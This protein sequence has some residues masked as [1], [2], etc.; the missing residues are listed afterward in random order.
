MKKTLWVLLAATVLPVAWAKKPFFNELTREL[1]FSSPSQNILC[2]GDKVP[3]EGD[4]EGYKKG[5]EC[6]VF[7]GEGRMPTLPE[8][9]TPKDCD[10]SPGI[11]VFSVEA[12]G[13][14]KREAICQ[15]ASYYQGLEDSIAVLPYGETLRGQGWQCTSSERGM[16]CEN[17]EKNGFSLS[18]ARQETFSAGASDDSDSA[19]KG[20]S[21]SEDSGTASR[22]SDGSSA[23]FDVSGLKKGNI[24]RNCYKSPC[25]VSK[26][27]SFKN[28][29][30][31]GD[32]ITVD[33]ELLGGES[34]DEN[35][36]VTWND[37]THTVSIHCSK[38]K[39][40]T[41]LDGKV[42]YLPIGPNYPAVLYSAGQLYMETC[43]NFK[44]YT[45]EDGAEKFGYHLENLDGETGEMRPAGS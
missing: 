32:G 10:V 27:V 19:G 25:A 18:R 28:R 17:G 11:T 34:D 15:Q 43:H 42:E 45:V 41:T 7:S 20:D 23:P 16:H 3:P 2:K 26:L 38:T 9:P 36:P 6:S 30:P 39:P 44:S 24:S 1:Q 4:A 29:G 21:A 33:L 5:V 12:S 8:L 13:P 35:S 14:A 31:V 40:S 22:T 37:K